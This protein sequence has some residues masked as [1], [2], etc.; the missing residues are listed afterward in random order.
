M[1]GAGGHHIPVGAY[2]GAVSVDG[3]VGGLPELAVTAYPAVLG[4]G[5]GGAVDI[6]PRGELPLRQPGRLPK[7]GEPR[8]QLPPLCGDRLRLPHCSPPTSPRVCGV[9]TSTDSRRL[10]TTRVMTCGTT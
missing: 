9:S 8:A 4:V 10:V 2:E 6:Q 5:D 1:D 3:G 7:G